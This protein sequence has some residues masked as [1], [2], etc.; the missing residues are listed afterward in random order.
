MI[1]SIFLLSSCFPFLRY[2]NN[3]DLAKELNVLHAFLTTVDHVVKAA[4][5]WNFI[6]NLL[7]IHFVVF[8][9]SISAGVRRCSKFNSYSP[10]CSE[11]ERGGLE[12]PFP[13]LSFSFCQL[14]KCPRKSNETLELPTK[15]TERRKEGGRAGIDSRQTHSTW[16]EG[17]KEGA[18]R[19]P[20]R[21]RRGFWVG[22]WMN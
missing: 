10:W 5:G 1:V 7:C 2:S 14:P 13:C 18:L 9:Q 6:T 15:Q 17:R 16:K 21:Q 22:F 20:R 4:I 3:S 12:A 8:M 19:P 11:T